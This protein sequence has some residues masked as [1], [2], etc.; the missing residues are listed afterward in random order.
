[1]SDCRHVTLELIIER[2]GT[3]RCRRCSLTISTEELGD[4]YCPE[5]FDGTGVKHFDFEDV[6]SQTQKAARYRCEDCGV[7]ISAG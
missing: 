7:I 3:K 6:V 1:M 5:C 2:K 4:G